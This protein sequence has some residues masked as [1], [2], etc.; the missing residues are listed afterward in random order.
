MKASFLFSICIMA[1]SPTFLFSAETERQ[2]EHSDLL[3]T[4]ALYR[5]LPEELEDA[6]R[7]EIPLIVTAI[8]TNDSM[9]AQDFL[10]LRLESALGAIEKKRLLS[11]NP[12][13]R[14]QFVQSALGDDNYRTLED[15]LLRQLTEGSDAARASASWALGCVLFSARAVPL[16]KE[17]V[18]SGNRELQMN[19][20]QSLSAIGVLGADDLQL[21]FLL[22][23]TLSGEA[24]DFLIRRANSIENREK[25]GK[26]GLEILSNNRNNPIV[27]LAL[28][29]A[30]QTREDYKKIAVKLITSDIW[31]VPNVASTKRDDVTQVTFVT[32]LLRSLTTSQ[33]VTDSEL[34]ELL[35]DYANNTTHYLL[36]M[37]SLFYFER[38]G[39]DEAF[40]RKLQQNP[41]NPPE[42]VQALNNILQRIQENRRHRFEEEIPLSGKK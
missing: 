29:P 22:S 42:K 35:R 24:A 27:A 6:W 19:A 17:T 30:L 8:L 11:L 3:E 1:G 18:F 31:K 2:V 4:K 34:L 7:K 13:E 25:I 39:E 40:F 12:T 20:V 37:P 16:L 36:Y 38:S 41:E 5:G 28:I 15:K 10:C 9:K 23:G 26:F 14:K 32:K 21:L 33:A